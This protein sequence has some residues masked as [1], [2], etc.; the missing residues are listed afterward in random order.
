[1]KNDLAYDIGGY[2]GADTA[3]YLELGF[4]VICVEASPVLAQRISARFAKEISA[5]LCTVL[6]VAVAE[7]DGMLP[8]YLCAEDGALSSFDKS[9]LDASG[10]TAREITVP[11]R[12]FASIIE[13]YGVPRFLKVDIEGADRFAILAL[14]AGTAPEFLSFEASE[15]DT[16]VILH[17]YSIGYRRFNLV[18]QDIH[19]PLVLCRPGSLA[20]VRWA[21]RQWV[22]MAL[23]KHVRLHAA[24]RWVRSGRLGQMAGVATGFHNVVTSGLTPMEQTVGWRSID[25]LLHDWKAIIHSGIIG[26]AWFDIHAALSDEGATPADPPKQRLAVTL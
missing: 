22:R 20:H 24:A 13:Q 16:D 26:S 9:K 18:R 10:L 3:H 2:D 7:R 17:L 23:R 8:F 4:R 1:M 12:A 21:V 6:N 11:S 15:Q 14:T 19:E 5:G 25:E